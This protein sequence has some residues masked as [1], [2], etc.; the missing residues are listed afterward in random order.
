MKR[1]YLDSSVLI[2]YSSL[3]QAEKLKKAIVENAVA[4]FAHFKDAHLCTSM[5]AVTE[6]VNILVSRKKMDR[7]VVAET[8]KRAEDPNHRRQPQKRYDFAEFFYHVKQ[9]I[10]TTPAWET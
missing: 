5:W 2:A 3:D 4:V 6:M 7:G 8:D 10:L 9:G 1:I